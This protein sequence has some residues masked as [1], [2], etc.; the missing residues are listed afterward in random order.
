VA[1]DTPCLFLAGAPAVGV[2]GR[3][4]ALA[5]ADA[6]L[7]AWLALEG[8]GSRERLA[9]LLWPGSSAEAS[10]NALRQR[11]FRLR[12][13]AGTDLVCGTTILQL[14]PE[15]THDLDGAPGLLADWQVPECPELDAWLAA[16]RSARQAQTRKALEDRIEALEAAGDSASALPL[17]L[18]LLQIEP[19][20]EDAHRRVMRLHYLRGDRAAALLAFDRCEQVLKHEIGARPSDPTLALLATIEHSTPLVGAM[21]A[22]VAV[23]ASVL[24]PPRLVGR[25]SE[26]ATLQQGLTAGHVVVLLGEAGMGKSRLLQ[27]LATTQP[28]LLHASGRPGDQPGALRQPGPGAATGGGPRTQRGRSGLAPR[29]VTRAARVG[30]R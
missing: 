23:P 16:R 8:P 3:H 28:G 7:L 14:A 15:V 9:A 10:R 6:L 22:R 1:V 13:L 30:Q 5:A 12:K 4:H 20:S 17:A 2:G 26:L 19:L 24:R 25:D 29:P 11:L 21:P 18:Q 27:A